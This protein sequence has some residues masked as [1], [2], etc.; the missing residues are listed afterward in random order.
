MLRPNKIEV[1]NVESTEIID[2]E[3]N[4]NDPIV[5]ANMPWKEYLRLQ[6]YNKDPKKMCEICIKDQKAKFNGQ[7][8]IICDGLR[9][10]EEVLKKKYGNELFK[11]VVSKLDKEE[12]TELEQS[13]S[14]SGWFKAHMLDKEKAQDRWTQNLVLG[15]S[16]KNKSLRQGRRSGK[17]YSIIIDLLFS[18]AVSHKPLNI[19]VAAPQVTMIDEIAQTIL[20]LSNDLDIPGFVTSKKSSPI[21]EITFFNGSVL[22]GITASNDGTSARGKK[23]DIIWI[24]EVDFV[25][26]KALDAIRA[27]QL[28]NPD[29]RMIYTSTPIGEGNLHNFSTQPTT[30]EFH[31]PT[32]ARPDYTDE[33]HSATEG[34]S[35]IAYCQEILAIY[36]LDEAGVFQN[37]H[38]EKAYDY[39]VSEVHND[40]FVLNNRE[41]FIILIGVDWNHDNNGTR[42]VVVGYDKQ[43]NKFFIIEKYRISKIK[44]TQAISV[45][46]IIEVNRKFNADH[47]ICD[48]G[49][50]SAQV[51]QLRLKGEDQYGKV[52]PDHPDIKLVDVV[53]VQFAATLNIID[54]VT[55]D[56]IKKRTKQYLVEYTQKQLEDG[57]IALHD[58]IDNDII[59]QMKNYHVAKTGLSGNVYKPKDKKIGDHD[60][61]AFMLALYGFDREY[62]N[63]I[64]PKGIE[65]GSILPGDNGYNYSITSR[66]DGID[67]GQ[68]IK[69]FKPANRSFS[70]RSFKKRSRW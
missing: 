67:M 3:L 2:E 6:N 33:M 53:A 66:T 5:L 58:I 38:I 54:P 60:L 20:Q 30:K 55:G 39:Y 68:S 35:D 21:L 24:D 47:I 51:S 56:N 37:R 15:C 7:V 23:A 9:D 57:N 27:I 59:M 16:A 41:R 4:L 29:V 25:P 63:F 40:V 32:F 14:P 49:F 44:M 18:I 28:D 65:Y 48:E 8:P 61:D 43:Y 1:I 42:I 11:D 70:K 31:F 62:G 69:N 13:F 46:T 45:E 19:L 50:G 22:K 10:Y 12:L 17:T 52:P 64:S 36:G 26:T 34:M